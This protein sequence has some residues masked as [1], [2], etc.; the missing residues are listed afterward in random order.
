MANPQLRSVI[1]ADKDQR[2]PWP[3]RNGAFLPQNCAFEV[4]ILDPFMAALLVDKTLIA[5]PPPVVKPDG[6]AKT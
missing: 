3:G 5:A 4:S 1:L 2:V 6:K